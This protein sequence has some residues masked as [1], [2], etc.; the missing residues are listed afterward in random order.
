LGTYRDRNEVLLIRCLPNDV[1][2]RAVLAHQIVIGTAGRHTATDLGRSLPYH[3][4]VMT[5]RI[6][7]LLCQYAAV[8]KRL[9]VDPA[10]DHCTQR[11][12]RTYHLSIVEWGHE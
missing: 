2:P 12:P 5:G 3:L 1:A 9:F 11:I 4:R 10:H 7:I 6:P 8:P